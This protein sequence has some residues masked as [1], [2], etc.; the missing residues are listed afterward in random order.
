[1]CETAVLYILSEDYWF[2][3]TLFVKIWLWGNRQPIRLQGTN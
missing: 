2:K 3:T 1:M